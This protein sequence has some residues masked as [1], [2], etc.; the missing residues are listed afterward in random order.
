[1]LDMSVSYFIII[2]Y[3]VRAVSDGNTQ[4]IGGRYYDPPLA[5][6]QSSIMFSFNSGT[7]LEVKIKMYV[8]L[9]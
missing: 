7:H 6:Q 5:H 8:H 9:T 1:M 2:T 4:G 3:S